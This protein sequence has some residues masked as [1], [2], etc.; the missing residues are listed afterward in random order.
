MKVLVIGSGGREHALVWKLNQSTRVKKIY[1]AP[2]NAGIKKMATCVD[3]A[4]NDIDGLLAFAKKEQI[5]LTI[6]GPEDPLTLGIVDRFQEEGLRIFGPSARGAILEGS[7]VFT[8]DFLKKYDIPS[9]DYKTFI[10]AGPAKK[11]I[12]KLGAPCVVKADGLAAGKGVIVAQ[13]KS[14][15]KKAVDLI[16]KEKAFGDAGSRVVVEEFLMGEEASF[17]AFTDGTTILP[18]PSSQDHKAVYEGDR[19]PNTG[20][21]GA[22]S[23]A[24]VMTEAMSMRVMNEVMLPTIRGMEAEGRP[25]KGMLYA[26]M[27]IDGDRINVLEFN[28]RFGDPECQPLLMKMKTDLVDVLDAVID[29]TLD[30]IELDIDPRPTVCVVMASEGYPGKYATGKAIT[31]LINASKIKDVVVFHAGT[32]IKNRRT[33]TAGG[34]VL[35]V[36]AI[37]STL[38]VALDRAY[39]AVDAISWKG[40]FFR[41]DIG[42]RALERKDEP[43][44]PQVGIV[45]GSDSDLPAMQAAA[46]FLESVNIAYELRVSSAHRTPE[47]AAE[48]ARTAADRGLQIIIAGAGMSAHLAGVLA[49]H[50]ALPVIGVPLDAS[51]LNGLDALLSTVQMPPGIPV[52]T[53]GIGEAGAK[54]GAVLAARIIGLHDKEVAKAL[55]QHTANMVAQVEEKNK[56]I[57][58]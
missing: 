2:G 20:G 48:Y 16:L 7:K 40:T 8:K 26:G 18:L 9:A 5:E 37:G 6:V 30:Q 34:R 24:P 31:G 32:A 14:E 57:A 19:G 17:I 23:P 53:M 41:R 46:D 39:K 49:A 54:N 44:G 56:K 45:M 15:A 28:C 27:M 22:Y 25:Y 13:T 12:D 33:V 21:M 10:K 47:Q 52:A 4:A 38:K 36:T 11:Y 51:C 55:Q 58:K 1:C 3:C 43:G 42:H 29:S 50:T 35:G